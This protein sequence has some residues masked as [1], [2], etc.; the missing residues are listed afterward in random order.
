MQ[1]K[2]ILSSQMT[3]SQT[4]IDLSNYAAGVYILKVYGE[5]GVKVFRL[6][7]K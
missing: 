4:G 3:S 1:G 6:V 2:K 7:K 5:V